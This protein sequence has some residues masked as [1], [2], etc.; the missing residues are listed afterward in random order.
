MGERSSGRRSIIVD[1]GPDRDD[2]EYMAWIEQLATRRRLSDVIRAGLRL[3]WILSQQTPGAFLAPVLPV[4]PSWP[5]PSTGLT[6]AVS[7]QGTQVAAPPAPDPA[8]SCLP[9]TAEV[10]SVPVAAETRVQHK[11]MDLIRQF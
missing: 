5:M 8:Q 6:V 9:A 2:K 10:T 3:Q 1:L 11:L 4:S 7:P